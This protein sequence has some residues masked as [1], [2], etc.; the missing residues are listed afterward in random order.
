MKVLQLANGYLGNRLYRELF[1]RFRRDGVDLGVFVP[2]ST[3]GECPAGEPEDVKILPCFGQMDRLLFYSKQKKMLRAI[4]SRWNVSSFDLIHAHTV[5]S[6][7]YAAWKLHEKYGLPYL[8]AVRNTDVNVFFRYMVHLRHVGVNILRDAATVIFLSPAYQNFVIE[9]YVPKRYQEEIRS[10]SLVLPNGIS[11]LF[12]KDRCP[13][14]PLPEQGVRLA[15]VGDISENKNLRTTIAAMEALERQGISATLTV[16][17]PVKEKKYEGYLEKFP[18]V[19]DLGRQP[20]ERVKAVLRQSDVFVMPSHRETFGLVY[21]EA[22]SQGLPVLYTRGQGFDGH[23][24]DGAVGYAV[25]D[26]DPAD[27]AE[28]IRAAMGNY[29]VLARNAYE[30]AQKFSWDKIAQQYLELYQSALTNR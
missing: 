24:P 21:A 4:E 1:D 26:R 13:P 8:V 22:M 2:V 30:S 3:K 28:K 11:D 10:R 15:Y 23:F 9:T 12:V 19:T 27:V 6:G 5:F 14:H 17:G 20:P 7:G 29:D 18:F 25:D 16:A